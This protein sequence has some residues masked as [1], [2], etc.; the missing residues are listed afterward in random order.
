MYHIN[1]TQI[2]KNKSGHCYLTD[3]LCD[4]SRVSQLWCILRSDVVALL[5]VKR[6]FVLQLSNNRKIDM[7][8]KL[9]SSHPFF[10]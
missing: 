3:N 8:D 5:Q 2:H 9:T 10:P 4:L 1:K 6:F 7:I